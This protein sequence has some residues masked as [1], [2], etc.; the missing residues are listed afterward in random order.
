MANALND[1]TKWH[2]LAD[3]GPPEWWDGSA[4]T[5]SAGR[6]NWF[7]IQLM[8]ASSGDT[9]AGR[10]S[11]DG[12]GNWTE[13]RCLNWI[14]GGEVKQSWPLAGG[15]GVVDFSAPAEVGMLALANFAY[16]GY[17]TQQYD[18]TLTIEPAATAASYN[19]ECDDDYPRTTLAQM[20]NRL[21]T[22]LGFATQVAMGV[23]PPGMAPLL[24][25]FIRNAQ[26]MLYRR[27]S[28]FRM[29]RFYVWDMQPGVR[30]YDFDANTDAC[31]KHMDPRKVTWCGI[32]QGDDSWRPLVCG[33]N[34]TM[35][36]SQG[37]GI[38]SHYE[39]RQCIEVWPAPSDDTWKLRAKGYFGLQPL[40]ADTDETTIDPEAIFLFA[41]ANAKAHYGQ[42]DANNYASMAT[43]YV[44]D[45]VRGQHH[46]RR[47]V[48]GECEP[49]PVGGWQ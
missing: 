49:P 15:T 42:P 29:E 21:A 19:C 9:I 28:V 48:P 36:T 45:L 10:I 24:D 14:V 44:R 11:F 20:R 12:Q 35:Y 2:D 25:D 13:G 5:W 34:P 8:T 23:L 4:Y 30:F 6:N 3:N 41:L 27:Y 46:T 38:P 40:V 33:I 32:S 16:Q 17:P 43:A 18:G 7:A 31:P 26:D 1:P 47:Y 37:P 22:R 39:I